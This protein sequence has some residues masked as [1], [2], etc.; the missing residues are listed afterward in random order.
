MSSRDVAA[1]DRI[2]RRMLDVATRSGELEL[3]HPDNANDANTPRWRIDSQWIEFSCG[4]RAERCY[5][6][7]VVPIPGDPIIFGNL[8]E[9][10]VYDSVCDQHGASMNMF[11]RFAGYS[12]FDQWKRDRKHL[13]LGRTYARP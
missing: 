8:P 4:C 6:L 11:V 13:L 7:C 12:T 10:A 3:G 5:E 2:A 1:S 9:Q